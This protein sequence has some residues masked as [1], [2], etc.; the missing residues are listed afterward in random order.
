MAALRKQITAAVPDV[1]AVVVQRALQGDAAAARLL[2]ERA[3]PAVRAVELPTPVA[4]P[5][6]TFTHRATAILDAVAA[7]QLGV[8]QG[9]QLL[10]GVASLA[11]VV[12]L[13]SIEARLRAIEEDREH[14]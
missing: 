6:T 5:G 4:I 14:D 12:E 11:R 2:I 7:G 3:I 13:D 9:A 8:G 1:L 10:A